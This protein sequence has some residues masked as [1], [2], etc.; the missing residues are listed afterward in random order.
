MSNN[1]SNLDQIFIAGP[2]GLSRGDLMYKWDKIETIFSRTRIHDCM[3][4]RIQIR[5]G[6]RIRL[7]EEGAKKVR[8]FYVH[9]GC[10]F[11]YR[12]IIKDVA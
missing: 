12:D 2:A 6:N 11:T 4:C 8:K 1:R 3:L 5:L 7:Y 9:E 10:F